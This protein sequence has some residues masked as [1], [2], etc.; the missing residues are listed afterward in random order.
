VS[1][2]L[3]RYTKAIYLFDA[4]VR[5]VPADHWSS[6]S[7]CPD[8]TAADVV[9]HQIDVH[10]M[11]AGMARGGSLDPDDAPAV[12][13]DAAPT[14]DPADPYPAWAHALDDVLDALDTDGALQHEGDTPF[15]RL[16]VDKL[17]GILFV[18]P[19]THA[20]DLGM[21]VGVDPALDEALCTRGADQLERAG[22]MIRGPGL[23]GDALPYADDADPVT[24]FVAVAGRQA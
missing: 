3:R 6:P 18:D 15:G 22:D 17:I 24:R 1:E 19:L 10:G 20:W 2:K 11:V 5:R 9:K 4:V 8:W 23:Y 14:F 21:A 13:P 12:E 16:T 7:P